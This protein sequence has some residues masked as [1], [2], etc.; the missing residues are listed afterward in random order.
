MP[1]EGSSFFKAM[2]EQGSNCAPAP[3]RPRSTRKNTEEK[4]AVINS[5][6]NT[7]SSDIK[8]MTSEIVQAIKTIPT[9]AP[10]LS[11]VNWA[12]LIQGLCTGVAQSFANHKPSST[13]SGVGLKLTS[14]NLVGTGNSILYGK[15]TLSAI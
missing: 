4:L 9:Q 1:P 12:P 8:T 10:P 11:S 13:R 2:A 14:P 6:I 7:L 5:Q 15:Q 3:L